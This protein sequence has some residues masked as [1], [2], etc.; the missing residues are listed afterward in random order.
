MKK[1]LSCYHP[2]FATSLVFMLQSTEYDTAEYLAWFWRAPDLRHVARRGSLKLTAKARLL[3]M[4]AR[5]IIF[6]E[7]AIIVILAHF[8]ITQ[9][10]Y[11]VAIVAFILISP[12]ITVYGLAAVLWLGKVLV[13]NPKERAIIAR[14]S[15][16]LETQPGLRI[17]IAGS[18]GKTTFKESLLAVLS[19]GKNVAATPGNMNTPLGISRFIARLKGD[20][21]VLIFEL[22]EYYPGDI[23]RLCNLVRPQLGVITGINEAHLSKFKTLR[24][25]TATI[26]E[27]ADYLTDQPV[28]K[29]GDNPLVR[30]HSGVSDPLVYTSGGVNG[31]EVS[32]IELAI[33][34]TSFTAKKDGKTIHA[35][36]GLLG[37][38]NIGP[39]VACIDIADG[40][41][42]T[43]AQITAGLKATKPY[44]HRMQPRQVAGAWV[45]DDT[46][47]GNSDGVKAGLAWLA[48]LPAARRIYITPGLVEQGSSTAA[49]HE[50]I[51]REIAA[52][53]DVVVLIKNSVTPHIMR[54][55]E[56]AGFTGELK[57]VDNPVRFY[58]NLD[59]FVATGDVVLM[60][61]DWTD[62]YQ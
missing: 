4:L 5:I 9:A 22:G 7:A 40:L 51:G 33:N 3:V 17:A 53:A 2:R 55:L 12:L 49:V 34:A 28:Y 8:A 10:P 37:A 62:N 32:H 36:S 48:A 41:G 60:Q 47:N 21:D 31:W 52:V 14:A 18:Y 13:Q 54:G 26:F 57:I 35:R 24:A 27:L 42:L 38:Q 39:L 1:F 20:E 11:L 19:E 58:T 46:Y 45:I 56:A 16:T 50:T 15:K 44:E 30:T 61:N 59:Q 25:T 43:T 23:A 29:N 6:A